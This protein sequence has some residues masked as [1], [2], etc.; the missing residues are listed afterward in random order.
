MI[1]F[2]WVNST[3]FNE[4]DKQLPVSRR[5]IKE[6]THQLFR[7]LGLPAGEK[8]DFSLSLRRCFQRGAFLPDTPVNTVK[9]LLGQ[10]AGEFIE[11]HSVQMGG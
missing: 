10:Q 5:G 1:F 4:A 6:T 11:I 3:P 8:S 7:Q 2:S 9:I